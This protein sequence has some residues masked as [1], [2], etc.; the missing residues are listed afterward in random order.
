VF[1]VIEFW[2]ENKF[3]FEIL[4]AEMEAEYLE[5]VT[6]EGWRNMLAAGPPPGQ[7]AA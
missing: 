2:V 1:R 6:I 7:P 3:L 5:R 4:T